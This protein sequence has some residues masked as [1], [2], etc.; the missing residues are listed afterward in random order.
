MHAG[1]TLKGGRGVLIG[2]RDRVKEVGGG[3]GAAETDRKGTRGWARDSKTKGVGRGLHTH[4][5]SFLLLG[6]TL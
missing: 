6:H 5:T 3:G 1:E 4:R 2:L